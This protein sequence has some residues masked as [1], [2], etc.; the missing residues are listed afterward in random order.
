MFLTPHWQQNLWT[1]GSQR[2]Q[3]V[4]ITS[5]QD[6]TFIN[7]FFKRYDTSPPFHKPLGVIVP[8]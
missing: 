5:S 2:A 6:N 8:R 7:L 1:G 4:T 3:A